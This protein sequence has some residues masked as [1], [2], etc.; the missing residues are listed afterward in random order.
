MYRENYTNH[1]T[2]KLFPSGP[3][4]L[5]TSQN[6]EANNQVSNDSMNH[7]NPA[8]HNKKP[9]L[10]KIKERAINPEYYRTGIPY[11][12]L[13]GFRAVSTNEKVKSTSSTP[14]RSIKPHNRIQDQ[15]S[16]LQ[17][18]IN[19]SS[20]EVLNNKKDGYQNIVSRI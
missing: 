16:E 18:T 10:S 12:A 7:S 20:T 14:E 9:F 3:Q 19:Y 1:L 15:P 2:I 4:P 17:K 11:H 13:N 5:N 8:H 6:S